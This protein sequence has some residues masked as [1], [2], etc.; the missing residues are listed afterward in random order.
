M[1][2]I[3]YFKRTKIYDEKQNK[4]K[5]QPLK[6]RE[7]ARE[8]RACEKHIQHAV[9]WKSKNRFLNPPRYIFLYSVANENETV[10]VIFF[11]LHCCWLLLFTL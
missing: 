1:T 7:K 2:S 8:F 9:V 11:L 4:S 5:S 6:K 10:F 3:A